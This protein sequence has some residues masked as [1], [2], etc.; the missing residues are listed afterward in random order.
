M[1]N[2]HFLIVDDN[3][4]ARKATARLVEHCTGCP[5]ECCGSGEEALR[6]FAVGPD[7]FAC[8][9][10][11]LE[12]PGMDGLELASRLQAV[13]PEVKMLLVTGSPGVLDGTEIRGRGF[14]CMLAKPFDLATIREALGRVLPLPHNPP[15]RPQGNAASFFQRPGGILHAAA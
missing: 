12:M 13:A 15:L 9:V 4:T 3:E 14:E 1:K 7:E 2:P 8:V 5:V 6:I 11:D 10:T